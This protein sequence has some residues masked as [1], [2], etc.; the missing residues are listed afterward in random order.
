M[1]TRLVAYTLFSAML[2][3]SACQTTDPDAA[4]KAKNKETMQAILGAFGNHTPDALDA[5]IVADYIEHT[6]DPW[7][8]SKG[9]AGLKESLQASIAMMPDF[10]VK[11]NYMIAEGD[12]VMAH[13]TWSGTNTGSVEGMPA[14]GKAVSVDGVDVA[15]FKDGKGVEHWGYFD[16]GKMMDQLGMTWSPSQAAPAQN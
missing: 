1:K 5:L 6:P 15:R 4:V 13:Y 9:L 2:A 8:K 7:V 3:I 16:M 12:I 10:K 11:I 14:T